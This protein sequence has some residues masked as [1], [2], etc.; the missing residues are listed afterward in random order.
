V[1]PSNWTVEAS[2]GG[3][4]WVETDPGQTRVF[5]LSHDP[6]QTG[7]L[8]IWNRSTRQLIET[9]NIPS[10]YGVGS[11]LW[12]G[13]DR[14]AFHSSDKVFVLRTSHIPAADLV[15]AAGLSASRVLAGAEITLSVW[16]TNRGP[17]AASGVFLTNLLPAQASLISTSATQGTIS[18]GP[19]GVTTAFGTLASSGVARLD[20]R[21][22]FTNTV[23][24]IATHRAQAQSSVSEIYPDNDSVSL[25]FAVWSDNDRDGLADDWEEIFFGSTSAMNGGPGDDFDGDGLTNLQEFLSGTAPSDF[26]NS[27]RILRVVAAEDGVTVWFYAAA[28]RRY[29]LLRAPALIGPWLPGGAV[30]QGEGLPF[31][32]TAPVP[33]RAS[34]WFFRV[35]EL[36]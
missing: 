28:G 6:S 1:N 25:A 21:L 27:L 20:L 22:R 17:V 19:N 3:G 7:V 10:V 12:C 9:R 29:Q 24:A 36:P 23:T 35:A 11:L 16:V 34:P 31:S 18:S 4:Q 8:S 13:G 15:V 30:V 5:Y 2:L 14:L 26:A 32:Q 33:D